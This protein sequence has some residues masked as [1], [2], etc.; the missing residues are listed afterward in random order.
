MVL[1]HNLFWNLKVN[2]DRKS[3]ET[4]KGKN[5]NLFYCDFKKHIMWDL[6]S[7]NFYMYSRVLLTISTMLYSRSVSRTFSSWMIENSK[8]TDQEHPIF[9]YSP[10]PWQPPYYSLFLS[11]IIE[12]TSYKRNHAVFVLPLLAY[13]A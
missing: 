9:Y 11:M 1:I 13:I 4:E 12:Y 5:M 2:T 7:T 8:P 6:H 10:R 3:K